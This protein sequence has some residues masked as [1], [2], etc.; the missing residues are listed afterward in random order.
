MGKK[1]HVI[2]VTEIIQEICELSDME[3]NSACDEVDFCKYELSTEKWDLE[4]V[5]E[6]LEEEPDR[7]DFKALKSIMIRNKAKQILIINT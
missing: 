1:K 7:W 4:E 5:N 6:M 2:E 3:W